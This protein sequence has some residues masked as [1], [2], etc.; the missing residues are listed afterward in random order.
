MKTVTLALAGLLAAAAAAPVAG[1]EGAKA[2]AASEI[3]WTES[4]AVPGA[5]RTL[6][7]GDPATG[8]FGAI[9]RLP[10]GAVLPLHWHGADRRT[11][12]VAG[13]I[14][15]TSGGSTKDLPAGSYALIPAKTLHAAT[16]KAGADCT[17]VEESTGKEDMVFAEGA[18]N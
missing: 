6:L 18:K 12:V 5:K 14:A 9:N 15:F 3:Q 1:A 7:W 10:A 11:V 13:T 16:C 8:A 2:V 4:K 17:Y